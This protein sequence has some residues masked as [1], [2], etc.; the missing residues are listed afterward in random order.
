MH[1]DRRQYFAATINVVQLVNYGLILGLFVPMK[2]RWIPAADIVQVGVGAIFNLVLWVL[3]LQFLEVVSSASYLLPMMA[4][5]FGDIWNF[6]LIFG[7][8]Q[9]GLTLIFY[10]LFVLTSD[11]AFSSLGQSFLSTYFVMFGQVPLDALRA[12]DDVSDS[13]AATM[14]T[15][16]AILMMLHSAIVVVILL[17]VLLALM[18]Q[19]VTSG[20]EKA[21]TQALIS[22][23]RCILRLEI[24]MNLGENDVRHLTHDVD[25]DGKLVLHRI[26]TERVRKTELGLTTDQVDALLVTTNDCVAWMEQM[27]DLDKVVNDQFDFIRDGLAHVAHF[28]KI[29]VLPVFRDEICVLEEARAKM[30]EVI[31]MARR[32][33]G[34]FRD[35]VLYKLRERSAKVLRLYTAKLRSVWRR[36]DDTDDM[37]SH[38]QCMLLFQLNQHAT[39]DDLLATMTKTIM[40]AVSKEVTTTTECVKNDKTTGNERE[41]GWKP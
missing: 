22:Y 7:I 13:Y 29:E 5:L 35:E 9:C 19:T 6:F 33:R 36:S 17:N 40:A 3:S 12:Y 32:S 39:L 2:L 38:D 10:Q 34:Q 4:R 1:G 25:S 24:T 37:D 30:Q 26:F 14:Y 15:G 8:F 23:A 28:T 11:A 20:L 31:D 21:R 41:T 27:D 16:L 18:N